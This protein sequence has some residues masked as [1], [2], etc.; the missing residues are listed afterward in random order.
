M[1]NLIKEYDITTTRTHYYQRKEKY[2]DY[3]L[4]S[5]DVTVKQFSPVDTVV[6][7]HMPLMVEFE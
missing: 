7:D 4:V 5:P 6:S 2:A 3:I 1:R